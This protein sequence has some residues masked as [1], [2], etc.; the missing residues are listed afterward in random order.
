M[1]CRK[2][3]TPPLT[4]SG[5]EGKEGSLVS[6]N[7][8]P[9]PLGEDSDSNGV[10]PVNVPEEQKSEDDK[11]FPPSEFSLAEVSMLDSSGGKKDTKN[12]LAD[13]AKPPETKAP[14]SESVSSESAFD[15]FQ[16]FNVC[17]FPRSLRDALEQELKIDCADM[18]VEHI[19][20]VTRL[21][22]RN[23]DE[24]QTRLLSQKYTDFFPVLYDLDISNNP[25]MQDIPE[26]A[27]NIYDLKKLDISR[28]GISEFH[29]SIC[30]LDLTT[31]IGSHNN[32]KGHE[33]PFE[34]FCLFSLKVLD[35]SYSN[36]LY[37]DQYI[38]K[39]S[40]LEELYMSGNNLVYTPRVFKLPHLMLVDFDNA[41]LSRNC[42]A[43][44]EKKECQEDLLS[45][46]RSSYKADG[47]LELDFPRGEPLRG[48]YIN[49]A[50][51]SEELMRQCEEEDSDKYCPNFI[52]ECKDSPEND[53]AQCM[54][55]VFEDLRAM[56]KHKIFRDKCYTTW[57]GYLVDNNSPEFLNK[58]IRGITIRELKY[59]IENREPFWSLY[60]LRLPWKGK[61]ILFGLIDLAPEKFP[62]QEWEVE[63]EYYRE[64]GP[65]SAI[66]AF[67]AFD[68]YWWVPE[69]CPHLPSDL[70][71][72]I[73]EIDNR[74]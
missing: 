53:K 20:Q 4:V 7:T 16:F 9:A 12:L 47:F 62:P 6:G 64:S 70:R 11:A 69:D 39:L 55:D 50:R 41:D 25:D 21:S 66:K 44:E 54:L 74:N 68:R 46:V 14:L 28:T 30:N 34:T 29:E 26:F 38:G 58:T 3:D 56:D 45:D 17:A 33:V 2:K 32:Y 13:S 51:Q 73:E 63:Q 52:T 22:L 40:H 35:M 60:W 37:V 24:E 36:I 43:E 31:L 27:L 23:I 10:L 57:V 19:S 59:L 49:L 61:S 42:K 48:M 18:T 5:E 67:F 1:G 71:D 15:F 65:A 72:R 8:P